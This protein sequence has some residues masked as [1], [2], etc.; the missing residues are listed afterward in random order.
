MIFYNVSFGTRRASLIGDSIKLEKKSF[1]TNEPDRICKRLL[2]QWTIVP[3]R[4][5]DI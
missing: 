2:Q 3:R 1:L 5:T 4:G